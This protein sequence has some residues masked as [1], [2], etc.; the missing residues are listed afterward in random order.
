MRCEIWPLLACVLLMA[1]GAKEVQQVES[2]PIADA[3]ACALDGMLLAYHEG[4][5]AQLLRKN[6]E[7]AFF[8]DC[9]EI[10]DELLDPVRRRQV[11]GIWFQALDEAEW[12]AHADGW[13]R[14]EALFFVAGSTKMGAMGPTLAPFSVRKNAE[15]FVREH[16][17]EIYRFA[18]IGTEQMQILREQAI[19]EWDK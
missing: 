11:A 13:V 9:K 7:R 5:K 8:C 1:C 16:G 10:F 15:G 12:E 6:G 17:G 18:E 19:A 14:A 4:P 2:V 3:E